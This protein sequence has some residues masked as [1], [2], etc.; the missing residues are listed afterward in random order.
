MRVLITVKTSFFAGHTL[1]GHSRCARA[2]GH[3]WT[4][5]A[6]VQGGLDP[7]TSLVVDHGEFLAAVVRFTSQFADRNLDELLP[8]NATPEALATYIHEGLVMEYPNLVA[9]EV[10][11]G[12]AVARGEWD[13][14]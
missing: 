13:L 5:S 12:L 2:H 9:V 11:N 1:A 6:T 3:D 7:K 4:V 8:W 14:R 10:D